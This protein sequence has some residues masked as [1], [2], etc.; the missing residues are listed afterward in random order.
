MARRPRNYRAEYRARVQRAER[1]GIPKRLGYGKPKAGETPLRQLQREGRVPKLPPVPKPPK[2]IDLGGQSYALRTSS[3]AEL[4]RAMKQAAA[5]GHRYALKVTFQTPDGPRTR[6]VDGSSVKS[7][8]GRFQ[9]EGDERK[10]VPMAVGRRKGP[11][12][13]AVFGAPNASMWRAQAGHGGRS[14]RE[15]VD[16]VELYRAAGETPANAVWTAVRDVWMEAGE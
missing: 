11:R 1:L 4:L 8:K 13:E 7:P 15:F 12:V 14:A 10:P 2:R 6:K 5:R 9:P 3:A 16:R